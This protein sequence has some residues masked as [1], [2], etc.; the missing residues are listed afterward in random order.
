MIIQFL[1]RNTSDFS[2][3]TPVNPNRLSTRSNNTDSSQTTTATRTPILN[4]GNLVGV[5]IISALLILGIALWLCFGK[6]SKPIRHFF[7]GCPRSKPNAVHFGVG[8]GLG[9][10][11]SG[12]ESTQDGHSDVE[13]V[14]TADSST[15]SNQNSFNQGTIES[16]KDKNVVELALPGQGP[17]R[18]RN[19][20]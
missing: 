16:V 2:T 9:T 14:V 4:H 8:D 3:R 6:W 20:F 11:S 1:P 13:K 19:Q 15:S 17:T 12:K 5:L 7:R 18:G 10:T